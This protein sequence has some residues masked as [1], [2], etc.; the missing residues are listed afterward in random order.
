V[1]VKWGGVPLLRLSPMQLTRAA[2]PFS[3]G[4]WL[5]E[6]MKYD[7]F[8]ALPQGRWYADGDGELFKP[9]GTRCR[10]LVASLSRLEGKGL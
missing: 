4:D 8:R 6:L 9:L 7:G 3:H 2:A 5:F 10:Q 1:L